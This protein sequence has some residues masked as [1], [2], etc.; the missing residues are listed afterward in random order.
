MSFPFLLGLV[1]AAYAIS[2]YFESVF[3]LIALAFKFI[4]ESLSFIQSE[5]I[6]IVASF[7]DHNDFV[8]APK[9]VWIRPPRKPPD[10]SC[11]SIP[12]R[13]RY[14]VDC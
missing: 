3:A 14:S 13:V 12:Q 10:K 11:F 1:S 2:F 9:A 8:A 5:R 4:V 6:Q 7:S